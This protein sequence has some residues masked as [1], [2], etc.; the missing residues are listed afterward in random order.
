MENRNLHTLIPLSDFNA[1][2]KEERKRKREE[3]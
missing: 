3:S 1:M 2:T